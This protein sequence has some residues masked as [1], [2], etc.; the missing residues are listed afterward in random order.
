MGP[1]DLVLCSG[2]LPRNLPFADR[3]AAAAAAGFAGVSI[4]GRDYAA[5]RHEGLRDSDLRA[6]L[7]EYGLVVAE[8][9]PAWWWLP[10][11]SEMHIAP[12]IDTE[13]VFRFGEA[14]LFAIADALGARSVNAV[15]VFGGGWDV[16]AAAEAFAGLCRRAAEHDLLVHIEW[17]PW[18]RIPDLR[19]A[20][21][22]VQLADQPN[23][24]LNV[25]AWHLVRSGTRVDD[26]RKV[27][28]DL[29][30]G[31]QLDDG[32]LAAEPNLVEA[33]LHARALPGDGEFDLPAIVGALK[34]TGTMAP[35]GVEVFSDSLHR[36]PPVE[37]ARSAAQATRRVME[38]VG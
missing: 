37:A 2:T 35:I 34:E 31:I 24:G 29:I 21:E 11:A 1:G 18:S 28:G 27:P 20:L 17:L 6:M 10:G 19:T 33:T 15:D 3:L 36:L 16:A 26:L 30:F 13:D 25:D 4:W 7:A 14:E 5:A 8:L 23:G 38:A 32:P 22:I 9:D 12:E